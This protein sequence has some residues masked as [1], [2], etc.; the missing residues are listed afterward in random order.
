MPLKTT[1]EPGHYEFD[2]D[3]IYFWMLNGTQR[4]RCAVTLRALE[5]L[6]TDLKRGN[7]EQVKCFDAN[8]KRI[9]RAAS[10]K[11]DKRYFEA[12]GTV[13]VKAKDL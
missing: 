1:H 2:T 8:R 12:D 11:F 13:M 4:Q 6:R 3:N 5:R 10:E 9:E 7:A